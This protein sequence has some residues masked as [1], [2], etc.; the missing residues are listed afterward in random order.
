M[1]ERPTWSIAEFVR[2]RRAFDK[3]HGPAERWAA[4]NEISWWRLDELVERAG[5]RTW[6]LL[7]A[8]P[9]LG[10]GHEREQRRLHHA[11]RSAQIAGFSAPAFW[12]S[13]DGRVSISYV[14]VAHE[15]EEQR[16]LRL[17]RRFDQIGVVHVQRT[18][19]EQVTVLDAAAGGQRVALARFEPAAIADVLV[20]MVGA[21]A[22]AVEYAPIGWFEGL[23][24]FIAE[25]RLR[26]TPSRL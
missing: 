23:A 6:S 13:R 22:L 7:L 24:F 2:A 4:V 16:A 3:G 5:S 8:P 18:P 10:P 25:R 19:F 26:T 14:L 15:V 1:T 17:A 21:G 11:L 9:E 20:W 12:R